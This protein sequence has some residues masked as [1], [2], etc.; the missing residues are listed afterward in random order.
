MGCDPGALTGSQ[1]LHSARARFAARWGAPIPAGPGLSA[2]DMIDAAAAGR[3]R[4][5]WA[6]GYDVYLTFPDAGATARALGGLDLLIV[7]DLFLNETA[8]AFGTVFLPAASVFERDGTFM[9][10][11]RRVQRVRRAVP[12]PGEAR[13]DL[14]IICELARRLGAGAFFDY[15]S[16]ESVWNEVRDVWPAGAGL[17]YARIERENLHWPC[18][19][20]EHPGTPILHAERFV[21][22]P[23]AVLCTIPFAPT[24]EAPDDEYPFLLSTGR[25]LYHFNAGTMT[26]RTPNVAL[27]SPDGLQISR[28]DAT[29]LGLSEGDEVRLESRYGAASLRALIG[30][31]VP[32]GMLFATFHDRAVFLNRV[33]SPVRDRL[34]GT[35]EYKVT[36]VRLTRQ[37]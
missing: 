2:M 30:E 20:E 5:L 25:E 32:P 21:C 11:D 17:S 36:A 23:R 10:S 9:N 12:P 3:L 35:P 26:G 24:D 8:A 6:V 29:R 33:T 28:A 37:P 1:D 16:A 27:R 19:S 31:E 13:S 22:G 18:P 4:A 14:W 34:A 7:Q 15:D